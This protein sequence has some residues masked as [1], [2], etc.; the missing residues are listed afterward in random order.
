MKAVQSPAQFQFDFHSLS[1]VCRGRGA[2]E[3]FRTTKVDLVL[4][5]CFGIETLK[6]LQY[7]FHF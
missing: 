3:V 2:R 6:R 1:C 7:V 5:I 4:G